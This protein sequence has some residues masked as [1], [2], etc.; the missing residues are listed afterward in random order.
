[1]MAAFR[2]ERRLFVY[3]AWKFPV[4]SC[5]TFIG[6]RMGVASC[7]TTI[8]GCGFDLNERGNILL[9]VTVY[10]K[11]ESGAVA[12]HNLYSRAFL[13]IRTSIG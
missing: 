4:P 6:T 9:S 8:R 1:M 10:R 13:Y 11:S 3:L 5:Q 12:R 2:S 7:Q